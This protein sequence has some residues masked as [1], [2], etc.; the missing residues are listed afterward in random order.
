MI[1]MIG[2]VIGLATINQVSKQLVKKKK[3]NKLLKKKS[4]TKY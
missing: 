2:A 4:K 1:G 3:K